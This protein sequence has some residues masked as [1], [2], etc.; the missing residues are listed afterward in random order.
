MGP[1]SQHH[2]RWSQSQLVSLHTL[3]TLTDALP[4]FCRRS[5]WIPNLRATLWGGNVSS[6]Q[7]GDTFKFNGPQGSCSARRSCSGAD[8]GQVTVCLD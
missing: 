6:V 2:A 5:R 1:G 3:G 7:F 8:Q 4:T